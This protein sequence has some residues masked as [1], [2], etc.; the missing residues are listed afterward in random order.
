ML[1]CT[2]EYCYELDARAGFMRVD[3][4]GGK[5]RERKERDSEITGWGMLSGEAP[6]NLGFRK[7]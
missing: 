2:V 4:G 5:G 6:P 1:R 7:V 3:G